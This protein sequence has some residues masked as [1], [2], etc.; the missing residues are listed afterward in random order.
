MSLTDTAVRLA[1]PRDRAYRLADARGLCLLIQPTGSKWWRFR[2]RFQ[3][4][5]KMLSLGTYPNVSLSQARDRR[6]EARKTLEDGNDPS[7]ERK[8]TS[9]GFPSTELPVDRASLGAES[10]DEGTVSAIR[11]FRSPAASRND[12]R[13][14]HHSERA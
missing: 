5:E 1:K 3:G 7:A 10:E 12:G 13:E 9:T 11:S 8:E 6:D 4:A 14:R 2:Y